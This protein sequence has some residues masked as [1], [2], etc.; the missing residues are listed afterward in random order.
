MPKVT[1][2]SVPIY[3][4]FAFPFLSSVNLKITRILTLFSSVLNKFKKLYYY[5]NI[6]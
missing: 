2:E 6:P 1:F 4:K 5:E 3:S